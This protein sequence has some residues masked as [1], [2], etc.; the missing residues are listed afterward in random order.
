MKFYVPI[1]PFRRYMNF[2]DENTLKTIKVFV[3]ETILDETYRHN[4]KLKDI[5]VYTAHT[6]N[7][8]VK[9]KVIGRVLD[10]LV[11]T[12][13]LNQEREVLLY[14]DVPEED[15]KELFEDGKIEIT[16]LVA[17]VELKNN[18][19]DGVAI[20]I[21]GKFEPRYKNANAIKNLNNYYN[22]KTLEQ[23]LYNDLAY[24]A[25]S[26]TKQEKIMTFEEV[27]E[28]V[29]NYNIDPIQLYGEDLFTIEIENDKIQVKSKYPSVSYTLSKKFEA[30][31]NDRGILQ[32]MIKEKEELI[33]KYKSEI[34]RY[35]VPEIKK[36]IE[37]KI[38]K[39][40]NDVIKKVYEQEKD[41]LDILMTNLIESKYDESNK[42]SLNVILED[43]SSTLQKLSTKYEQAEK[44][45]QQNNVEKKYF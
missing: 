14:V 23:F 11:A 37:D 28:F 13:K 21:K 22:I 41:V 34:K 39:N 19:I 45:Q 4:P 17:S 33:N 32:S 10:I 15:L 36:I 18:I 1:L 16:D 35:K 38:Y 20:N 44:T 27:K 29:K 6:Y 25:S 3:D 5:L 9:R 7:E 2:T 40:G 43:V 30:L 26:P 31:Q 42:E 8:G 24:I 12:N